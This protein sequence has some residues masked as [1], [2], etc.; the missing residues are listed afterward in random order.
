MALTPAELM[1]AFEDGQ[2]IGTI[3]QSLKRA[4]A[5]SVNDTSLSDAEFREAVR[6]AVRNPW[7]D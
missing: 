7:Y 4:L 5:F 6:L 1:R 2:P 3:G